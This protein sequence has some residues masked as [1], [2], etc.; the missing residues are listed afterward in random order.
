MYSNERRQLI[1]W[2]NFYQKKYA[3]KFTDF[4]FPS[5]LR[6]LELEE[7]KGLKGDIYF[8]LT[9]VSNSQTLH[10][11]FST[12]IHAIESAAQFTPARLEGFANDVLNNE[13]INLQLDLVIMESEQI[14][15]LSPSTLLASSLMVIASQ[16][17]TVN[18]IAGVPKNVEVPNDL[19][20]KYKDL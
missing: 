5:N 10:H 3:H 8:H 9:A 13:D 12:S 1:A 7:L 14:I 17:H 18:S 11:L 15:S 20:E 16:R 19:V 4:D 2:I 6:S